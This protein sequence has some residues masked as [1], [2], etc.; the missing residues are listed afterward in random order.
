IHER[1]IVGN[2][3][4]T[5]D[6]TKL[7]IDRMGM[8]LSVTQTEVHVET[9]DGK[10]LRFE[11]VQDMSTMASRTTGKILPDGKLEISS[12]S[13]GQMQTQVVAWPEGAVLA[14]G[15]RLATV[16]QE[17][18]PGH[19]FSVKAYVPSLSQALDMHMTVKEEQ[20]VDLLGRIVRLTEVESRNQ[21]PLVGEMVSTTF[22]DEQLRPQKTVMSVMGFQIEMI[23]CAK[24]VA[25]SEVENVDLIDR[26]LVPSPKPLRD[27]FKKKAIAYRLRPTNKDGQVKIPNTD[28]QSVQT[29]PDGRLVLTVRPVVPAAGGTFPYT[30]QDP[31]IRAALKSNA[32]LQCQHPAIEKLVKQA[33]GDTQDTAQAARNIEAFVADYIESKDL[34]IGY[35]SAAEVAQSRQGDC[36]EHAVLTAALCRAAGIPAQV[37]VG[38]AY[39]ETFAGREH[40]FG[41]HAWTQAYVEDR[42]IGLD[43]AFKGT[44]RGGYGPGHIALAT[45]D[46]E[47]ADFFGLLKSLGQF[48]IEDLEVE[49]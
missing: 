46:G 24:S 29:T 3:V 27:V 39:V 22:V 9:R 7:T 49:K 31:Q 42:W 33:V 47:P 11:S 12:Q 8:R 37:A 14:E 40:V 21:M 43:A 25:L 10:P 28:N 4:K 15:M 41:G 44:G 30:G 17:L 36:T 35:A 32:V 6:I 20:N 13:A 2:E 48:E 19:T 23:A 18:T 38:I 45:G 1:A 16:R 34:S 5:T 26:M